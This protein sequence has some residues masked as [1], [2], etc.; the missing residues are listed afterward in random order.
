MST[1]CYLLLLV[2]NLSVVVCVYLCY[3]LLLVHS[4]YTA[5]VVYT[6]TGTWYVAL[7]HLSIRT[8]PV[9]VLCVCSVPSTCCA[10]ILLATYCLLSA[11]CLLHSSC[12]T[13]PAAAEA[14]QAAEICWRWKRSQ[15]SHRPNFTISAVKNLFSGGGLSGGWW[16]VVASN[17]VVRAFFHKREASRKKRG[18]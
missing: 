13:Q 4:R 15:T 8:V 9:P 17:N 3:L 7:S 11:C 14:Q 10:G 2:H 1:S 6:R 16:L 18:R 5:A 12:C